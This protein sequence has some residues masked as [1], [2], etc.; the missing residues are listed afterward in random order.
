MISYVTTLLIIVYL[1][2][3]VNIYQPLKASIFKVFSHHTLNIILF[4][5]YLL[6]NIL[7]YIYTYLFTYLSNQKEDNNYFNV[8][9]FKS[10]IWK[11]HSVN[12]LGVNTQTST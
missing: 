1:V 11:W 10:L 2:V 4:F 5:F 9:I 6:I 8:F 3:I 12:A 7:T